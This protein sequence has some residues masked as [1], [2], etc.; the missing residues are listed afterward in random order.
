MDVILLFE[1]GQWFV[2]LEDG[3]RQTLTEFNP[4]LASLLVGFTAIGE[5]DGRPHFFSQLQGQWIPLDEVLG[6][7]Q[8]PQPELEEGVP[9]EPTGE[10]IE[11]GQAANQL[12]ALARQIRQS[13]IDADTELAG[14]YIAFI[15]DPDS[16]EKFNAALAAA[17]PEDIALINAVFQPR[18][19]Q[20]D[21]RND[22]VQE[23]FRRGF[24][25]PTSQTAALFAQRIADLMLQTALTGFSAANNAQEAQGLEPLD[26]NRFLET[27][28]I[29]EDI[30][31]EA[32]KTPAILKA[33][34][35]ADLT[36]AD[37]R[38]MLVQEIHRRNLLPAGAEG[39]PLFA[40]QV[41]DAMLPGVIEQFTAQNNQ[42]QGQGVE[43]LSIEQFLT[44]VRVTQDAINAASDVATAPTIALVEERQARQKALQEAAD[45]TAIVRR[46]ILLN[47]LFPDVESGKLNEIVE[48]AA[49]VL[50]NEFNERANQAAAQGQEPPSFSDFAAQRITEQG[51]PT[52]RDLRQIRLGEETRQQRGRER[53][54][55]FIPT[56][57]ET[58][59]GQ[60]A[61]SE[62]FQAGV[63]KALPDEDEEFQA[64]VLGQEEDLERRL[65]QAQGAE[66]DELRGRNARAVFK[67]AIRVSGVEGL[68]E[69]IAQLERSDPRAVGPGVLEALKAERA[70][71]QV[72][73]QEQSINP[74]I[75]AVARLNRG[76]Q[77]TLTRD[78]FLRQEEPRLRKEFDESAQGQ[79]A[80]QR[81]Q[82]ASL[83]SRPRT[84]IFQPV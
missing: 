43:P 81:R 67:P 31:H 69:Q 64:F 25:Q 7:F 26:F 27:L 50:T 13:G 77:G 53:V 61:R 28:E 72:V 8:L 10:A 78:V 4:D 30:L 35:D 12:S 18:Q 46:E 17:R 37:V 47:N 2:I 39:N 23:I 29:P 36:T 71:R 20:V 80:A 66:L 1:N 6:E 56:E 79:L 83:R 11:P 24:L 76:Q 34:P 75:E 57:A 82:R 59:Q 16:E 65:S 49:T 70:R 68:D 73:F 15:A 33:T 52:T 58:P 62:A 9:A 41:A 55:S 19:T 14:A 54:F 48:N 3:T 40:Q 45:P 5:R 21:L 74:N 42:R 32:A 44:T 63:F 84:R 60:R 38:D 22:I 51:F